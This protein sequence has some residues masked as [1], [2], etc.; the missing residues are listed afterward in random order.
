VLAQREGL[1]SPMLQAPPPPPLRAGWGGTR[2]QRSH[3][4]HS[5]PQL[6]QGVPQAIEHHAQQK[7]AGGKKDEGKMFR[8]TVSVP[9]KR[10]VWWSPAVLEMAEHP[11]A[12]GKW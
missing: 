6:T 10:Y 9:S 2:S 5:W 8:V 3:S 1:L 4:W 11:P 7:K 12:N